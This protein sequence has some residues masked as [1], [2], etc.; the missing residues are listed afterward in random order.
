MQNYE[1]SFMLYIIHTLSMMTKFQS[2]IRTGLQQKM[3]F[4]IFT[5]VFVFHSLGTFK[6]S[7]INCPLK[8]FK[9]TNMTAA[10]SSTYN[11][12][13]VTAITIISIQH[14]AQY[15]H[16]PKP[17]SGRSQRP[18][19]LRRRSAAARRLILWVRMPPRAWMF[20]CCECC[21]RRADHSSRGVLL[22][23]VVFVCDL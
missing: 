13:F 22:S 19:G 15:L 1:E 23:V 18:R 8:L 2:T 9:N 14:K 16:K 4:V 17:F 20:V 5:T 10:A 6:V 12:H 3:H 11:F 21:V 7:P